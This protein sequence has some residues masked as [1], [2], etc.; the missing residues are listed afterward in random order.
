VG[1]RVLYVRVRVLLTD[2]LGRSGFLYL[3]TLLIA[4]GTLPWWNAATR[5]ALRKAVTTL[6]SLHQSAQA[7]AGVI[8]EMRRVIKKTAIL[9]NARRYVYVSVVLGSVSPTQYPP[10][11]RTDGT[12]RVHHQ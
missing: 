12:K 7:D 4:F 2:C 11:P 5:I 1:S 9:I 3:W 8:D 10:P 6:C